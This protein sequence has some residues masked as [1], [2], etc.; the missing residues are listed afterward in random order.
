M[1]LTKIISG[2]QT[3]APKGRFIIQVVS[4]MRK[5]SEGA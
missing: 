1:T 4:E 2:G 5:T 3:G